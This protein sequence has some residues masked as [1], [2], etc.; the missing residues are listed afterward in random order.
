MIHDWRS[1]WSN[2][3]GSRWVRVGPTISFT[4]GSSRGSQTLDPLCYKCLLTQVI[5]PCLCTRNVLSN[6]AYN[7]SLEDYIPK[8]R[9]VLRLFEYIYI[10]T[11]KFIWGHIRH[12]EYEHL[13]SMGQ[14]LTYVTIWGIA[15]LC[16]S[17]LGWLATLTVSVPRLELW[18]WDTCSQHLLEIKQENS[19][20]AD[21]KLVDC[22]CLLTSTVDK[23]K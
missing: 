4:I 22:S 8:R 7:Y 17:P 19:Y 15:R 16:L 18:W 1:T 13:F 2:I 20:K 21:K 10:H 23:T 11:A 12:S 6:L 9:F 14:L 3:K 5:K